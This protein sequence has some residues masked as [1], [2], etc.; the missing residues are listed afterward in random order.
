[1]SR[2]VGRLV[3]NAVFLAKAGDNK[4]HVYEEFKDKIGQLGLP[5]PK[6]EDAVQRLAE[7]LML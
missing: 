7:K 5:A 6:Y 3:E 4:Y 2:D 1:M